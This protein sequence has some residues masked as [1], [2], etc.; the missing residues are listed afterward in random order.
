MNTT[1][2]KIAAS[3]VLLGGL[4]TLGAA[5]AAPDQDL[6][7]KTVVLVH[8]AFADGSSWEK[9]VPLLEA[10]GLHVV[11]VQ[12]PLTSLADDAAAAQRTIDAQ[13][14]PVVLVGHSWGGAVI[15]QAGNDDKVK[16]LVYV[17]AFAPDSGTSVN[18]LIKD[19]PAPA[20]APELRKDSGNFLT[21]SDKG[22]AEDFAQ[23]LTPAQ[24]HLVAATQGPWSAGAINEKVTD[25][26]WHHK[27]SYFVI[28]D[29]DRMIDPRLQVAMAG[30]IN[31][32]VTHANASHV[33]MLSQ[34]KVVADAIIAAARNAE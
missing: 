1:F 9:V 27:R 32:T 7:G 12:N 4:F 34:P 10:R 21:L 22:I 26:A 16:A 24:Q 17:A 3:T 2:K 28:A 13:T 29:K 31:A 6:K 18:D 33:V 5:H 19:K 15:S 8:G 30:Q 14:G 25:A 23:D 11:A 20:W